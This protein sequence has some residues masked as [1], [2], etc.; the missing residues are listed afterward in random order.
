MLCSSLAAPVR[1]AAPLE[2]E[3]RVVAAI[4]A[5]YRQDR[6]IAAV[7]GLARLP[8]PAALPGDLIDRALGGPDGQPRAPAVLERLVDEDL[9]GSSAAL[10]RRFAGRLDRRPAPRALA[11][12]LQRTA[13]SMLRT[14]ATRRN[15]LAAAVLAVFLASG[16]MWLF[17]WMRLAEDPGYGFEVRYESDIRAMDPMG[18]SLL[19]GLTGGLAEVGPR[20]VNK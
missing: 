12:R 18:R 8:A 1:L 11:H 17:R 7:R 3:G 20:A 2:L 15:R 6:V 9:R 13:L 14:T 16:G 19:G 10:A 5:G 4:Q